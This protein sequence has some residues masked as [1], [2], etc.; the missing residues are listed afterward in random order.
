MRAECETHTCTKVHRSQQ[1]LKIKLED[2]LLRVRHLSYVAAKEQMSND[3][4]DA[5]SILKIAKDQCRLAFDN[6]RWPAAL[7]SKDSKGI[8]RNYGSVHALVQSNPT[9]T[10]KLGLTFLPASGWLTVVT[11]LHC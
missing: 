4:L 1:S 8:R 10:L 7:D 5:L 6:N 2:K 3:R 9:V 11:V